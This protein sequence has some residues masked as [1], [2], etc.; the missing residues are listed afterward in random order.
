MKEYY[1][2]NLDFRAYVDRYARTYGV[3]VEEAL[4]HELVKEV[5][6]YYKNMEAEHDTSK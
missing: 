5:Y 4:E 2:N 3:S 6:R 1:E